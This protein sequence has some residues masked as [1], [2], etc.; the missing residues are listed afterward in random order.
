MSALGHSPWLRELAGVATT[1]AGIAL[2]L[3]CLAAIRDF[4]RR[5]VAAA[6]RLAGEELEAL[7]VFV[8]PQ[9]VARLSALLL[10]SLPVAVLVFDGSPWLMG[11]ALGLWLATPRL[12]LHG[13]RAR[14]RRRFEAQLP[15]AVV[16]LASLLRAGL[17]LPQAL[18]VLAEHQAA[19]LGQELSLV[20]RRHRLGLV[21]DAALG[22][23]PLRIRSRDAD[24]FVAALRI[25]RESGA[26]LADALQRLGDTLRRR[27]M[28]EDRIRALTAQGRVQG[29][30]VSLLPVL[31]VIALL[32]I[33]PEATG[34][35]FST[36]L[37]WA[38]LATI[39]A[40]ETA[41]WL[42]IRRIVNI[43]V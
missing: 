3:G 39:V 10:L 24:M 20:L 4:S 33:E 11:F 5:R 29:V 21:L 13:L 36:P 28:I 22:E 34:R 2:G 16:S 7:F 27:R 41:G 17:A 6:L 15:E 9:R 37:G 35:L 14:R 40:L 8:D 31:L 18:A 38:A 12:L 32:L 30:I 42:L 1:V 26:G 23:L 25:A 43:D 19:P